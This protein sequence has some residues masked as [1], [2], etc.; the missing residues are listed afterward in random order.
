MSEARDS[1]GNDA[2][3]VG[4]GLLM[5]AADIVPG[6]S[7]GTM[8]LILGIYERLITA[9]SHVDLELAN[10]ARQGRIADAIE[11]ADL[12]FLATLLAGIGLGVVSLASLMHYLLEHEMAATFG[13]FFGLILASSWLVAKLIEQWSPV[14]VAAALFGVGFAFWLTGLVP[15]VANPTYPY[16]FFAGSVAICAMI[17]P[18]I[19]GAFVLLILG[20]YYHVTGVLKGLASGAISG[21]AI[22]TLVVF[23]T[24]CVTGI[25]VFS[26]V[27]RFLL[28][29]YHSVTMAVLCGFMFG[30]L[31]KIWPFK[32]EIDPDPAK[33]F[34]ERIFGNVP[35]WDAPDG[36]LIPVVMIAVGIALV[37]VLERFGRASSSDA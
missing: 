34:K 24:G 18:G 5:G 25:L 14:E 3:N 6:V 16:V 30:S 15:V 32:I 26:R 2:K 17:L 36:V 10:L 37:L 27:L 11:H 7:G 35:P 23:G 28:D 20:M 19:S 29:R 31:R 9:I 12:R 21:D 33:D 13:L 8:A 1:L 22:A 4:R